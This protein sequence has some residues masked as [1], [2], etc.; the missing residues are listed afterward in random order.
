MAGLKLREPAITSYPYVS[1]RVLIVD[2]AS[3]SY[4]QMFSMNTKSSQKRLGVMTEDEEMIVWRTKMFNRMVEYVKLFNPLHIVLCLEGKAAWRKGYV[5]DFYSEHTNVYF[6]KTSYYVQSYNQA[7]QVT[8]VA[9]AFNVVKIPVKQFSMFESLRCKKLGELPVDK[10]NML[11]DISTSTGTPIIPSYKGKRKAAYWPFMTDKRTWMNYKDEFA[12][13]L[14]PM[15]RARAVKCDCAEG[16][17]MIYASVQKF[18]GDA[19]DVIILTR[20]SDMS[21]IGHPKVK[22]FNHETGNFTKCIDPKKYLDAKVLAGDSSD[23]IPGMAFVDKKTGSIVKTKANMIG[24]GDAT[25]LMD[26]CP[27]IYSVAKANGWDEQYLRNRKLIDLSMVP[28]EIKMKIDMELSVDEPEVGPLDKCTEWG[29]PKTKIDY[30]QLL[31][32]FGFYALLPY[33]YVIANPS[34]FRGEL[35][36]EQEKED[37]Q[38]ELDVNVVELDDVAGKF[39]SPDFNLDTGNSADDGFGWDSGSANDGGFSIF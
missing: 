18:A 37:Q 20:D 13:E 27:N 23:N 32:T 11:W 29:V 22:I 33:D 8:K 19:D 2:W 31:K 25:T 36:A 30:Y 34:K 3:L 38:A 14:A 1:K 16:D 12:K 7:Y 24:E 15:F 6:D 9:D 4:H 35:F 28:D 5:R 17:D 39:A 26:N 10:Q 21:Q